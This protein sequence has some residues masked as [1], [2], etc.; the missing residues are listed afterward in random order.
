MYEIS[1]QN[2]LDL[3]EITNNNH[4][5]L[6]EYIT[7]GYHFECITIMS[8]ISIVFGILV[9]TAK[10]PI[11]SI[12]FL[13]GLFVSISAYLM[14]LGLYFMGL[15]YLLVYVGAISILFIFILMLINVRISELLTEG[16][17]SLPLAVLAVI[18]F[19]FAVAP[20]LSYSAYSSNMLS[21]Y[22]YSVYNYIISYILP[23]NSNRDFGNNIK[24]Y[25]TGNIANVSSNNWEITLAENNHISSIG[26]IMY[27]NLFMLLIITSLILLLAMVGTIVITV[28]KEKVTN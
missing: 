25:V 22:I 19:N 10:N 6:S 14:L 4:F 5:I 3:S 17:N 9:I 21:S 15:A 27:T 13:I 16:K 8:L 20:I 26:N 11:Y 24:E 7:N 18:S 23:M 2:Y 1:S 28:R 12:L